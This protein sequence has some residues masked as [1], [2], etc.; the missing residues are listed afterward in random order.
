MCSSLCHNNML[1]N[2]KR[3]ITY[4]SDCTPPLAEARVTS[5]SSSGVNSGLFLSARRLP[6]TNSSP[7]DLDYPHAV[8]TEVMWAF[9]CAH[10]SRGYYHYVM[11]RQSALAARC[12]MG[13]FLELIYVLCKQDGWV[14]HQQCYVC[15][16]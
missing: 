15:L 7:N 14:L 3:N 9:T 6:E 10:V 8:F 5:C 1:T 4:S 12:V 16:C 13:I 2:A 11:T